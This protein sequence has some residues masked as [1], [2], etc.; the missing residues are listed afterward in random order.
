MLASLL[1]GAP[2][3]STSAALSLSN[4]PLVTLR[5]H[6]LQRLLSYG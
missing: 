2:D 6:G 5:K 3:G 1:Y 4:L